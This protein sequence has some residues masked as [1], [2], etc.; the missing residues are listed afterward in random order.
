VLYLV[1]DAYLNFYFISTVKAN[2]VSNGL[3]KYNKL[4]R[5]N[6]GMILVS[7]SMDVVIL[8][9]MSLPN[10]LV[11]VLHIN[12]K[13]P[14]TTSHRYAMFHPLAYLVKLNIEMSMARLIKKIALGSNGPHNA[15]G[16]RS[17]NSSN[18]NKSSQNDG[19]VKTWA[20]RQS[21]NL[22]SIFSG[23]KQSDQDGGIQKTEEF[24]VRSAPRSE[25][26]LRPQK[27][28]REKDVVSTVTS[29]K[30]DTKEVKGARTNRFKGDEETLI[31]PQP[32]PIP[33]RQSEDSSATPSVVSDIR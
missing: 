22:K 7:L 4:V 24:T 26:E 11:Y 30:A 15:A 2:L 20:A 25:M 31:Q 13:S 19:S 33:Q 12:R 14:L 21:S 27:F 5:F 29:V 3:H 6:Q 8:G 16:F 23:D 28:L 32:V 1:I 17:F 18:G 9:T 10:G